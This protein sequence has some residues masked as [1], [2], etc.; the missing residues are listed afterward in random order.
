MDLDS[1]KERIN[2]E[3]PSHVMPTLNSTTAE[4]MLRVLELGAKCVTTLTVTLVKVNV[5]LLA[6][7]T[8]CESV[9]RRSTKYYRLASRRSGGLAALII[10][11]QFFFM[12]KGWHGEGEDELDER[13]ANSRDHN[14]P[15]R[16]SRVYSVRRNSGDLKARHGD[17]LLASTGRPNTAQQDDSRLRS[18]HRVTRSDLSG[19]LLHRHRQSRCRAGTMRAYCQHCLG[20]HRYV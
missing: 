3:H 17:L 18:M 9:L 6:P 8:E 11:S 20:E 2:T 16:H 10:E 14:L 7:K 19:D 15:P 13:A 5:N 1:A 12:A 4:P